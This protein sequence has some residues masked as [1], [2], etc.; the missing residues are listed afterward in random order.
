MPRGR[1]AGGVCSR[2]RLAVSRPQGRDRKWSRERP[3]ALWRSGPF[4]CGHRQRRRGLPHPSPSRRGLDQYTLPGGLRHGGEGTAAALARELEEE[5]GLDAARLP[6]PPV[7]RWVQDQI[8]TRPGSA[9][10]FQRLHLIHTLDVTDSTRSLIA[11]TE[12]DADD[13]TQVVWIPLAQ[14]AVLHLYPAVGAVLADLSDLPGGP[15]GLPP[16][17]DGTYVWR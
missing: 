6:A 11:A 16:M 3:S 15:V 12:Q 4:L 10:P 5:L 14:A 1:R 2:R 13:T 8:T 9:E 7:L 17:V